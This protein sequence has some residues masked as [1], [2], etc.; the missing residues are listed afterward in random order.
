[1]I[2]VE[3]VKKELE[4]RKKSGIFVPD[5]AFEYIKDEEQMKDYEDSRLDI[6]E[7]VDL[8]ISLSQIM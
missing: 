5:S 2:F 1:M 4:E 7:C 3:M 6:S 8:V